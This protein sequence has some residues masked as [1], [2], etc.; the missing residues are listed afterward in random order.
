VAFDPAGNRRIQIGE[1]PDGNYG[2][3]IFSQANDGTYVEINDPLTSA[4][5]SGA[6]TTT[7]TSFTSLTGSPTLDF[8]V[9]ASGKAQ[10]TLAGTIGLSTSGAAASQAFARVYVDGVATTLEIA[11]SMSVTGSGSQGIQ[12]TGSNSALLTGLSQG[13]HT[14]TVEYLSAF[15]ASVTFSA[16]ELTA[17]PY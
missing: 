11:A 4:P 15:G 12:I 10:V 2:I 7:S 14:L 1:L 16:V 3:A 9:G 17:I 6:L 13:A 5:P 8:T